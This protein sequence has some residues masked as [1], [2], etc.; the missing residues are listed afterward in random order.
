MVVNSLSILD[1]TKKSWYL[2][3]NM[4]SDVTC[5]ILA[6]G[7]SRRMGRDKALIQV[8]GIRL[9]D[10]VYGKCHDLFPEIIIVTNQP[11]QFS[12]YHHAYIVM[13]EIPGAGSLGGL[14][15]GLIRANNDYIFC[16]ACDMPFL[17]PA[18]VSHLV[19]RRFQYDIV[20]PVTGKGFE[21]LHALYSKRCIEPIKKMLEQSEFKISKLL[22]R[23]D[24]WYCREKE[25]KKI[26]PAL[27]SF[28]N[29]N[30]KKDLMKIW[31]LLKGD[32]CKVA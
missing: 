28:T 27:S 16:A 9:F 25:L 5:I 4:V 15:T 24:V 13:D 22:S 29:V 7:A 26:D 1:Q 2:I 10:Y 3:H 12:Q 32:R 6:G 18:L 31:R 23:V 21:P 19:A 30:T 8:E 11:Q 14:Y 17:K 20:M